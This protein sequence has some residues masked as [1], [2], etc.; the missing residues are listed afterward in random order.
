MTL[1]EKVRTIIDEKRRK[2][3]PFEAV[4]R[5]DLTNPCAAPCPSV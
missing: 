4:K 2:D 1:G 5:S 3:V